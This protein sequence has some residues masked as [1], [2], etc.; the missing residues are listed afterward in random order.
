MRGFR[1][2]IEG[3]RA[4][5]VV[6]V[7]IYHLRSGWLPGGFAGV[8]IF[9]VISGFLI[10]SH[11]IREW[12][13]RGRISL[14]RFYARRMIRLVPAATLTL[15]ATAAATVLFV[16]RYLWQQIGFDIAGAAAYI[17]NWVF[18]ARSVDYLAEDAVTSP[19]QHFWSLA[20]EEQYYLI[21]PL[22]IILAGMAAT[23]LRL[24]TR[25]MVVCAAGMVIT[26]SFGAA[27]LAIA[28]GDAT[29][30]FSTLTRLW[31]LAVGA[32]VAAA[33][34]VLSRVT[35]V[36]AGFGYAAG[37]ALILIA[38]V[39]VTGEAD[40]PGP[41]TLLPV[42]GTAMAIA[43]GGAG[44]V[45]EKIVCVKPLVWVGGI[46]YSLYLW[47]WP[48]IVIAGYVFERNSVAVALACATLS[49]LLAWLSVRFF[50]NPIRFSTWARGRSRNGL[51][52][53]LVMG[54]ASVVL[55]LILS[56]SS[57]DGSLRAPEGAVP[58]GA[59]VL[60]PVPTES[61]SSELMV[62]PAWVLPAPNKATED[63]PRLYAD[64][65]QQDQFSAEVL[66]CTYGDTEA[67]RTIAIVGDSK[68][69]QW[70]P[71]IDLIGKDEGYRVDVIT[72]S[73]CSLSDA[74]AR[75]SGGAYPSCDEWNDNVDRE[76]AELRPDVVL[77]SMASARAHVNGTEAEAR[78]VMAEGLAAKLAHIE[79]L[80]SDV[81]VIADTPHPPFAVYQ[82]VAEHSDDVLGCGFALAPALE[83]SAVGTQRAAVEQLGGTVLE[84]GTSAAEPAGTRSAADSQ[85]PTMIDMTDVIC[86]PSTAQSCPAVIG[87]ALI[88][89]QGSH[90]TATYVETMTEHL[91]DVLAEAGL[92]VR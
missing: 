6:A 75:K 31:E 36:V 44:T 9:F 14:T 30:Y 78:R 49:V 76:L 84:P 89:R 24:R 82:C 35:G 28:A 53:G 69:N 80:G 87:N 73:A 88:Y 38:L 55:G 43:F 70:L 64:G 18:A 4:I 21:W 71:A 83:L 72:K 32:T 1:A 13:S 66:R 3:L 54:A 2:D 25:V 7:L 92:E 15:V 23:K 57:S 26:L 33:A 20:V 68:A 62:E 12:A 22:L 51:S 19:V 56:W 58:Q 74:P 63:V 47:H 41:L 46:S 86:P 77:T 59:A 29:A 5:A 17:V 91:R 40:W 45:V 48:I 50:E 39:V 42:L 52:L 61:A 11:L 60:G 16:P 90:V 8:D 67:D 65:C 85:A 81:I 10:T 34:P 79:E 27:L 37:I